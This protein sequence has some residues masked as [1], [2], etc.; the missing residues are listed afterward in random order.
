MNHLK[1]VKEH[2]KVTLITH[3]NQQIT[4]LLYS[5]IRQLTPMMLCFLFVG[6][7]LMAFLSKDSQFWFNP[8]ITVL[9]AWIA[10][11]KN[12]NIAAL[13]SIDKNIL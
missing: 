1:I 8:A 10:T 5:K 11:K 4:I 7:L 2:R 3:I 9:L 12:R 13:A 6:S